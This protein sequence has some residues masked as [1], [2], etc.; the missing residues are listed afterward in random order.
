MLR[1]RVFVILSLATSA[2]LGQTRT[3]AQLSRAGWDALNAGRIQEAAAAFDEAL[4]SG[5]QQAPVL[6]GAGVTARLQGRNEDA[7][8]LL[9]DALKLDPSL[10]PASLLLDSLFYQTVDLDGAIDTYQR[11]LAFDA[12]H[13]QLTRQ[14]EAWRKEADL[15]SG[16]RQTLGDHFT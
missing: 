11:A 5:P 8:R 12:G 10:T 15:H 7:R 14:L 6:L 9:V 13:P 4:R 1:M 2:L 16:F 3:P